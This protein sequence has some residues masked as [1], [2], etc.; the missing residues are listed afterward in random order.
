MLMKRKERQFFFSLVAKFLTL[1]T[2]IIYQFLQGG[3]T[4]LTV[5]SVQ[6]Y[7]LLYVFLHRSLFQGLSRTVL[8]VC[9]T[10][11]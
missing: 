5:R 4:T 6:Q 10:A 8:L 11:G 7:N 9:W 2:Q 1:P 3:V